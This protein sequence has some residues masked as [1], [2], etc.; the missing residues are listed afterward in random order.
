MTQAPPTAAPA[1]L[2]S[3]LDLVFSRLFEQIDVEMQTRSHQALRERAL[4]YWGRSF[5][6]QLPAR[7]HSD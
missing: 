4:F 7:R 2:G 1:A 5:T 6:G 3:K